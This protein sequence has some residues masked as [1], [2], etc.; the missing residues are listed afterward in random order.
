[1]S[2]AAKSI[3]L[4]ENLISLPSFSGSEESTADLLESYLQSEGLSTE[5]HHQ[6]ILVRTSRRS[7]DRPNLL[8]CSHHDT[9]KPNKGYTKNPFEPTTVDDKLYGLGSN[10]AGGCLVSLI[11]AF[12]ELRHEPLPCNLILACVAEEEI[13]G[14]KGI[15]TILDRLP[16]I[17]LAIVGEPTR[18]QMAIAEKGLMV[19]DGLC[20]GVPGHAAHGNTVNPIYAASQDALTIQ[21][22]KFSKTSD[23]LGPT[24]ANVTVINSGSQHNQVPAQCSYVIDVRINE[25]YSHEEVL[26]ELKALVQGNLTARSMRLRASGLPTDHPILDV[27]EALQIKTFGS[28]TLSDQALMPFPSIKIGPGDSLR[29]HMADEF[30]YLHEI[31][32]GIERYVEI[33]RK[34]QPK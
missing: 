21:K 27:A 15:S 13:S 18:M 28:G 10:D 23:L 16:T 26:T 6:N 19:V 34:Y 1:M 9:V 5:R 8:L 11:A 12:L 4:L 14:K 29:S 32:T 7:D 30:I 25:L 31:E 24:M 22:H 2:K 17:D 20:Q 3:A 33:I